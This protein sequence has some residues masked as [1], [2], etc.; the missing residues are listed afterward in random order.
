MRARMYCSGSERGS[1][2]A[3]G[4]GRMPTGLFLPGTQCL[5]PRSPGKKTPR[6]T[7]LGGAL[8][9]QP[10]QPPGGKAPAALG[11]VD[12]LLRK[13][14]GGGKAQVGYSK[15]RGSSGIFM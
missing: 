14:E 8:G 12:A 7:T 9:S 5:A 6:Q 4:I 13:A 3:D 15:A 10:G 1:Q 11:D 2:P